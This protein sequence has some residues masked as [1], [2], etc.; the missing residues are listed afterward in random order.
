MYLINMESSHL[1]KPINNHHALMEF[2]F[3]DSS[4][5]YNQNID[6]FINLA[7]NH[8]MYR[9]RHVSSEVQLK[10]R[11]ADDASSKPEESPPYVIERFAWSLADHFFIE[12]S[13]A[14]T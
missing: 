5:L 2:M 11:K 13:Y 6:G 12:V 9:S 7:V 10:K 3:S 4:G 8:A 1:M 14:I